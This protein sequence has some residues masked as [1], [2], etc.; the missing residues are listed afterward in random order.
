MLNLIDNHYD[1]VPLQLN[2]VLIL[3]SMPCASLGYQRLA[4]LELPSHKKDDTLCSCQIHICEVLLG[5]LVDCM[6]PD[7]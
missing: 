5:L 7:A 2:Y 4:D 6:A 3:H 1:R